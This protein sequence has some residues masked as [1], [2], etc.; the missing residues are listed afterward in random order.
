MRSSKRAL[1]DGAQENE[2]GDKKAENCLRDKENMREK[3]I[4]PAGAEEEGLL[5]HESRNKELKIGSCVLC[6]YLSQCTPK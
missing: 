5:K 2:T 3:K 1:R 6:R 4:R